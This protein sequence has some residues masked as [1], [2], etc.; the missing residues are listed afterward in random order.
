MTLKNSLLMWTISRASTFRGKMKP[1][2]FI[3][4][5]LSLILIIGCSL[6]TADTPDLLPE[7]LEEGMN[8]LDSFGD[9]DIEEFAVDVD[10]L[11]SIDF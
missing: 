8:D 11:E 7:D 5:I 4:T 10:E 1:L 6:K 9:I 3:L 2:F